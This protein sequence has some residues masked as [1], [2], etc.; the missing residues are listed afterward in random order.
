MRPC[1]DRKDGAGADLNVRLSD[2]K[3]VGQLAFDEDEALEFLLE[4]GITW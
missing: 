3:T 2:W 1:A 4:R